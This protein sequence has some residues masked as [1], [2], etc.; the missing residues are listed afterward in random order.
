MPRLVGNLGS[1]KV[2]RRRTGE[3]WANSASGEAGLTRVVGAVAEIVE[4]DWQAQHQGGR[5]RGGLSQG[6][7]IA[8]GDAGSRP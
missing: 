6:E 7:G 3:A 4:R 1:E 8:H 5:S 2:I